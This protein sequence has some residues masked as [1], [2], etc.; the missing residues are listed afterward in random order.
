MHGLRG[1]L[2][3]WG[4][5]NGFKAPYTHVGVPFAIEFSGRDVDLR[6]NHLT[7]YHL[8]DF[9][10]L[11]RPAGQTHRLG[12]LFIGFDN[13]ILFAPGTFGACS[14]GKTAKSHHFSCDFHNVG[15]LIELELKRNVEI[16]IFK[17]Y[18]KDKSGNP[19]YVHFVEYISNLFLYLLI[20][21]S[22]SLFKYNQ[23]YVK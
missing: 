22:L 9:V 8:L 1:R 6:L 12:I 4:S 21:F 20:L 13:Q 14:F 11:I 23:Y 15:I 5:S 10:N 16:A 2:C 3:R 19:Q 7:R 18:C 17:I